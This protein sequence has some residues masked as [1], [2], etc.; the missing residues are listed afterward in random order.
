MTTKLSIALRGRFALNGAT[1]DREVTLK[2]PGVYV[3]SRNRSTAHYVG[4]SDVSVRDRLK[5]YTTTTYA[6]FWFAYATSARDAFYKE[7]HLYHDLNP[8]DNEV[9][10]RR[11]ANCGWKCPRCSLF[12]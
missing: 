1:I 4:R 10:P 11:P 3:L 12:G 6:Y 5:D 8:T 7:C 9:H 2:S